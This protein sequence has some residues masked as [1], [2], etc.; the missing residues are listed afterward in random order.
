MYD[1]L[2]EPL[3]GSLSEL[4]YDYANSTNDAF[5]VYDMASIQHRSAYS[6]VALVFLQKAQFKSNFSIDETKPIYKSLN[7]SYQADLDI[8]DEDRLP[9]VND[10]AQFQAVYPKIN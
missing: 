7:S 10:I 6:Y 3:A 9:T 5:A 4:F 2:D 1:N 8:P